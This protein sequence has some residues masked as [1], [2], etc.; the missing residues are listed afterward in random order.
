MCVMSIYN[1]PEKENDGSKHILH[2][3]HFSF[4]HHCFLLLVLPSSCAYPSSGQDDSSQ[5]HM[6][7]HSFCSPLHTVTFFPHL[8]LRLP[9]P[10]CLLPLW[11]VFLKGGSL[12]IAR[13]LFLAWIGLGIFVCLFV[14]PSAAAAN[15]IV[16]S[17]CTALSS[18]MHSFLHTPPPSM[19]M[20]LMSSPHLLSIIYGGRLI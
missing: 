17:L 20:C 15:L 19:G 4:L 9:L 10:T 1:E 12:Q 6:P 16:S 7:C 13:C 8:I 14:L 5:Q 3:C 2:G 11:E 18:N